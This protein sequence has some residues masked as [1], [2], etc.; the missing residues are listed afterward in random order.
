MTDNA[1]GCREVMTWLLVMTDGE[2]SKLVAPHLASCPTCRRGELGLARLGR[3]VSKF[4]LGPTPAR[5][6]TSAL[7]LWSAR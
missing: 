6:V 2:A 3:W 4:Q 1:L 5:V 7:A